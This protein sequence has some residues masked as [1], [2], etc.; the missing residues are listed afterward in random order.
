METAL[1][2]MAAG[3]GSRFGGGIK[4]LTPVGPNGEKIIDYSIHDAL[5]AGFTQIVFVIRRELEA[6]MRAEVGDRIEA[7]GVCVKYVYQELED[8]PE[9]FDPKLAENRKKPWGTGQAVLACRS[10]VSVPFAVINADDY[11]GKEAFRLIHGYLA[12]HGTE[13]HR[14]CMAGFVLKNT[15]SD[16]GSV[17]RGLC[18]VDADGYLTEIVETKGLVRTADGAAAGDRPVDPETPVSMN[19]WGFTPEFLDALGDGFREY[20]K[21]GDLVG[22]EY[23]LPGVVGEL[24]AA[25]K[26]TVRCLRTNDT[27]F[28][29]TYAEDKPL[30]QERIGALVEAGVYPEK[31]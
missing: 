24:L 11:Y 22:G 17:T 12:E 27:W 28:G 9:G 15:L 2:I 19:V 14:Y 16:F 20:L 8:L 30:V 3:I 10:A 4:Q 7:K 1:V 25:G 5:E 21:T 31:L 29:V 26:I 6:L 13:Q 18:K 23:L